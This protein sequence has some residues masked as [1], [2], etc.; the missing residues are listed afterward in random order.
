MWFD[1]SFR[2]FSFLRDGPQQAGRAHVFDDM[3]W[4]DFALLYRRKLVVN[5][6][7]SATLPWRFNNIS[8]HRHF[9]DVAWS[10]ALCTLNF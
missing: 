7:F 8:Y 10:F 9:F 6:D 3:A 1:P 2:E 4:C 5:V